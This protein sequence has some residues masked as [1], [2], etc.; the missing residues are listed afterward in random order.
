MNKPYI[1]K[2]DTFITTV[3]QSPAIDVLSKFKL[4]LV[5]YPITQTNKPII[6]GEISTTNSNGVI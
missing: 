6:I 3:L 5:P 4:L 1:V 2:P